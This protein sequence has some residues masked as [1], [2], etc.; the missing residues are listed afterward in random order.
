MYKNIT[1]VA[2]A[3]TILGNLILTPFTALGSTAS[4]AAAKKGTDYLINITK[5]SDWPKGYAIDWS[6]MAIAASKRTNEVDAAKLKQ[7][8]QTFSGTESND[9]A[10]RILAITAT[11][12]DPRT[13][14]A[15]R[16]LVAEFTQKFYTQNQIGKTEYVNDDFWGTMALIASG[17]PTSDAM[18]KNSQAYI[19]KAQNTNGGFSFSSQA[20]SLPDSDD[21]AAA[22]MALRASGLPA[23]DTRLQKAFT[24]LH[25]TQNTDGGFTSQRSDRGDNLSNTDTTAW[26][27]SALRASDAKLSDWKPSGKTPEDFIISM[28]QSDGSFL[29]KKGKTQTANTA[30]AVTAL[31]Q[32][33]YPVYTLVAQPEERNETPADEITFRIEGS[34]GT[35]CA[36]EIKATNPL[37]LIEKAATPCNY[38]YELDFE[39]AYLKRINDDTAQD[40]QGWLYVVNGEAGDIG[41]RDYALKSGDEVLWYYGAPANNTIPLHAN[42]IVPEPEPEPEPEISLIIS[43]GPA[44]FGD[45]KPGQQAPT[46]TVTLQNSGNVIIDIG[47]SITGAD[48]FTKFTTINSA[49]WSDYELRLGQGSNQKINLG[50]TLPEDYTQAGDKTGELTFWAT[51]AK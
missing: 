25:T 39:G 22:I 8:L 9:Y 46:A 51:A 30:Y 2:L 3:I 14:I 41:A 21:T 4:D 13:Y 11:G 5:K 42:V 15:G 35:V 7:G 1:R 18:I 12:A 40:T 45:L 16:D 19:L 23:S 38:T 32:A 48:I 43:G 47:S 17:V 37:E 31:D 36:D 20:D 6:T 10:K 33:S 44:E 28:Q 50:L 27:L 34:Q 29:W 26:A 24:Y 49:L